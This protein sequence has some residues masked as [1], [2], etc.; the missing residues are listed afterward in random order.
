MFRDKVSVPSSWVLRLLDTGRLD[1]QPVP[2]LWQTTTNLRS[3]TSQNNEG[4]IY[5]VAEACSIAGTVLFVQLQNVMSR[6]IVSLHYC[7]FSVIMLS[8]K[9][10]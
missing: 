2:K 4:L 8:L 10:K 3:V 7:E 6:R 9:L 5:T 1:R